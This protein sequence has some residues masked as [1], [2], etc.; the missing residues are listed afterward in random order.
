MRIIYIIAKIL[1]VPGAMLHAFFEH[2]SCRSQKILVEDARVFQANEMM[3]HIDHELVKRKGA[4]FDLCFIPFFFNFMLGLLTLS[5]GA[6][7][8][9][10]YGRL[11]DLLAWVC[12]YLGISLWANL[13]PQLEDVM[14]LKENY[15][16]GETKKIT[17]V[18]VAPFYGIF[19]VGAK[20]D[21]WG[22][23][24][25]IAIALSFAVPGFYGLFVPAIYNLIK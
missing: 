3:G 8:V 13:F 9:Y 12:L 2:L 24:L 20:L 4:S 18:L 16:N 1:T 17:K 15:F 11:T 19:L 7:V 22:G 5:Y 21:Q 25:L 10:Y 23:T 14:M 6:T